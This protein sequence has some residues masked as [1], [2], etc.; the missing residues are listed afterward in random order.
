MSVEIR[1]ARPDDRPA[2]HALR[3]EVFVRGQGVP[4]AIERDDHD[5]TAVHVVAVDGGRTVGTGRLLVRPDGT[6]SV[7]RMAVADD[8]RG[9]D[10]GARMLRRLEDRAVELGL[11]AVELHA[12]VSARGFYDR[13]GYTSVGEVYIEAGIEH[14]T[15]RKD[16]DRLREVSDADSAALMALIGGCWAEYPGVELHVDAEEPWLRAPATAYARWDGRMWVAEH[17]GQVV[18]CCG[19]KPAGV[20]AVELKSMYVAAR[21]RRRGLAR[22]LEGCV[23]EEARRR[24]ARRVELWSDTRFLDAHATYEALGYRRLPGARDLHDLSH[25]REY[26]FVKELPPLTS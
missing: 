25:S 6:A 8:V 26:P 12:Q 23:L 17:G 20:D 11:A 5:E 15:M 13:A 22:R 21:A 16:L 9:R 10:I 7:G 2:L 4:A 14:V 24:G 18:A 19:V 1:L 3:H